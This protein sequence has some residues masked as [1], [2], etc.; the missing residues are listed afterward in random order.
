MAQGGIHGRR[1]PA[2]G[3]WGGPVAGLAMAPQ[4]IWESQQSRT[5]VIPE[6]VRVAHVAA[7]SIDRLVP[8]DVHHLEQRGPGSGRKEARPQAVP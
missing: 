1:P 8:A 7:Q 5:S 3:Y 2:A 6:G 4:A